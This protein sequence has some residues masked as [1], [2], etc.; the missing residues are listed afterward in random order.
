MIIYDNNIKFAHSC[1]VYV[2]LAQARP[3]DHPWDRDIIYKDYIYDGE[4]A[5][6]I[7]HS[8][9]GADQLD[10]WLLCFLQYGTPTVTVNVEERFPNQVET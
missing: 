1:T 3:N 9:S 8:R 6:S 2:G 5:S 10:V 7:S 4:S